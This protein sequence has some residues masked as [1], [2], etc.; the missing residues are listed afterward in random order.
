MALL[1]SVGMVQ[2][3][4][5]QSLSQA[6]YYVSDVYINNLNVDPDDWLAAFNGDIC[7]G[8]RKWDTDMCTNNVC[9]IGVMGYDGSNATEGYMLNGQ[10]PSFKIYDAS[11]NIYY[12]A[13]PSENFSWENSGLF[14]IDNINETNYYCGENPS[15]SGCMDIDACNY[16]PDAIVDDGSCYYPIECP[17]NSIECDINDCN[18]PDGFEWNQSNKL[19]FIFID[20]AY[21]FNS[22]YP[23]NQNED[24]IAGFKSFDETQNGICDTISD[25]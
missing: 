16:N 6:F 19:F 1:I 10:Y 12:D 22:E 4:V 24:W 11:E 8:A 3:S 7:V 9:D 21:K 15:C 14:T 13:V 18:P 23:L 20:Y 25:N 17:D 2:L 5:N